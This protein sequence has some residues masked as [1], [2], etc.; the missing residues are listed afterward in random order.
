[1]TTHNDDHRASV[2]MTLIVCQHNPDQNSKLKEVDD[3]TKSQYIY[4]KL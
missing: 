2:V 3:W 1:M 4:D